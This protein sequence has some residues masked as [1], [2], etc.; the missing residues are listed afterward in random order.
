MDPVFLK[1][2]YGD[3]FVF[4]GGGLNTQK[5]LPFGTVEDVREEVEKN[6][7][8]FGK[9]GGFI[10][11]PEHNIQANV[12]VENLTAMFETVNDNRNYN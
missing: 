3:K 2:N 8:V 6:M 7:E 1:K 11:F 12:P 9:G 4:W 10:F 5:T